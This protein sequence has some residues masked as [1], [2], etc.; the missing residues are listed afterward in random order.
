MKK[1]L[2][3]RSNIKKTIKKLSSQLGQ[4]EAKAR[5]QKLHPR[6]PYGWQ[7]VLL[8]GYK[9]V[10]G[11]VPTLLEGE[12]TLDRELYW[13]PTPVQSRVCRLSSTSLGSSSSH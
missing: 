4:D 9:C 10:I 1:F 13:V 6:L 12:Y 5:S 2:S 7:I 11:N 3:L 8:I